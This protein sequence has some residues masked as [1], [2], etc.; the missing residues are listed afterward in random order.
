M[1]RYREISTSSRFFE[2]IESTARVRNWTEAD[3]I[4]IAILKL[5]DLAKAFYSGNLEL[6][7]PDIAWENFKVPFQKRFRDVH[8]DQFHFIQL[9]TARQ[10]R[11]ETPR[12]LRIVVCP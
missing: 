3:K 2:A 4:Q 6:H 7:S 9:Q 1:V 11:N 8:T 5:T 12:N 10:K